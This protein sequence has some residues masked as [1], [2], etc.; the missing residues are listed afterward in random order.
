MPSYEWLTHK[1]VRILYMDIAS[2][3]PQELDS[4][5]ATLKPVIEKEPPN[6]IR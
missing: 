5:I 1:N 3:N 6:S 4:I 2:Q